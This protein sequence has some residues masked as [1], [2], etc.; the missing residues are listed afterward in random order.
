M[1]IRPARLEDA[2]ALAQLRWEFAAETKPLDLGG[3]S[4]PSPRA[5]ATFFTAALAERR[6]GDLGG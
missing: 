4:R 3:L 1:E 6:L 5:S 2:S